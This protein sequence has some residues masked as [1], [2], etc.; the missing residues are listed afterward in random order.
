M[1]LKV[2]I[3][4]SHGTG[5]STLA[6]AVC[7]ILEREGRLI[8][9]LPELARSICERSNDPH[10]FRRGSNSALRQ[11]LLI[12]AQT[13]TEEELR[14]GDGILICDRTIADHWSYT[15]E[16]F[17]EELAESG[18]STMFSDY[19]AK[20]LASYDLIFYL[21]P[22]FPPADDGV[23]EDDIQFQNQIAS[24]IL[25]ELEQSRID[26]VEVRGSL[27]ARTDQVINSIH[28]LLKEHE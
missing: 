23:R 6:N 18:V 16:L 7:K 15:L 5:K 24:R 22:E 27:D 2:A 25:G 17:G 14:A 19:I 26:F 3:I 1:K 10:F 13:V 8:Q 20:H 21:P 9:H 11:L 12:I 28:R 4:G